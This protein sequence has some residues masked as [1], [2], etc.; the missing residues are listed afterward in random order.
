MTT[1]TTEKKMITITMSETA[2]V[3]LDPAAWPII[4]SAE[5]HDGQVECQANTLLAVKVREHEDGRRVVYGWRKR[6]NGGQHA[7]YREAYAGY[8]L[9]SSGDDREAQTIR[10]IRRVAGVIGDEALA[11]ECIGDLPAQVI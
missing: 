10:A 9:A 7:G 5:T 3:K 6:G 4:A 2:P 1:T 11:A 8:L